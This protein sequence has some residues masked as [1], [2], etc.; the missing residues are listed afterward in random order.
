LAYSLEDK[1]VIGISSR[2]L[3]DLEKEHSLFVTEGEDRYV[4]H[5]RE[6][7]DVPLNPGTGF[8]LIKAL[9]AINDCLT[10]RVVEVVIVSHN[11]VDSGLRIMKSARAAGLDITRGSFVGGEHAYEYLD[12]WHCKLFLSASRGNVQEVLKRGRAAALVFDAPDQF[13]PVENQVRIAFDGDAVIFDAAAAE[14]YERDGLPKFL[15]HEAEFADIPMGP[16]PL[17]GF[18]KAIAAIQAR[19]PAGK[20]SCPIHTA[21]VTSRNAPAEERAIK[22]LRAWNVRVDEIHFLGGVSKVGILRKFRPHIYFD[23]QRGE[24]NTDVPCAEVCRL[25]VSLPEKKPS[26]SEKPSPLPPKEATEA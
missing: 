12:D 16:G 3:F 6:H 25:E 20:N 18:L 22:T 11:N 7:E 4:A 5:M 17:T 10:D 24:L 2:A 23:D 8:P 9:L 15:S 1:L 19:F 21:V 26:G 13:V 14:I